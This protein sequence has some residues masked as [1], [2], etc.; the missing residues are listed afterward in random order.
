MHGSL[1]YNPPPP[2]QREGVARTGS[3][4]LGQSS[5]AKIGNEVREGDR[6][7]IL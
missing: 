4:P 2:S 1:G 5:E 7:I 6:I 3:P